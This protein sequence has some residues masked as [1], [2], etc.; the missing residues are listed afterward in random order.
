[1]AITTPKLIHCAGGNPRFQQVALGAGFLLGARLPTTI[2]HPIYFADQDWRKPN[3]AVYMAALA[4]HRP[5]MAT[6]L[7][8]ERP[9]QLAEVLEWAEEAAQH[10]PRVLIIPKYRGAIEMLPRRIGRADVV[11][12]FSVPTAYGGTEVSPVVFRGWPVHL[13]GGSPHRQ[14]WL[15]RYLSQIAD[16]VSVDGN[17]ANKMAHTVR[18][19]SAAKGPKGHWRNL[20]EIGVCLDRDNN[21]EAFRRSCVNIAQA[22]RVASGV[23]MPGF[24]HLLA[25]DGV[26]LCG[27][28]S[29]EQLEMGL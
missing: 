14:M 7:D 23:E 6:V 27:A 16:V 8:L 2:Y 25:P 1:M 15:W 9:E 17:M 10:V 3:R 21:V 24:W 28:P 20:R 13:L 19:W 11:L 18:F 4:A 26:E 12:A 29:V 22:W 5:E